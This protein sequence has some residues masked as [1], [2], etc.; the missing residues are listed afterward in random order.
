MDISEVPSQPSAHR[1]PW[2]VV[3]FRFFSQ[4]LQPV[5][6]HRKPIDIL[7]IGSG[8]GWFSKQLSERMPVGTEITCWDTG[9]L[10]EPPQTFT[11]STGATIRFCSKRPL[12]RFSLIYMLDVLEHVKNDHM[13][14]NSIVR[15]NLEENGIVLVSV[16]AWPLVFSKHDSQLKHYRRYTPADCT[17]ILK[18]SGLH[19]IKKGGLF[20]SLLILRLL[21]NIRK[22]NTVEKS[23]HCLEWNHSVVFSKAVEIFLRIDNTCSH[24]FSDINI[25]IPGLSWWALC[26]KSF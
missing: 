16:P 18:D 10:E 5:D 1:H 9:Y 21:E 24:I 12:K 22:T 11:S 8:D 4:T 23:N 19:I 25:E 3:R 26:K 7:D 14:L 6:I 13:F 15:E 20:H 2:E 17:N